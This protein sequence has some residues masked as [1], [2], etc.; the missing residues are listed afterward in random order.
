MSAALAVAPVVILAVGFVAF[1]VVELFRREA[2]VLPRWAWLLVC[3]ASIPL[4]GIVY[5][6]VGRGE[7]RSPANP[8]TAD[9]PSG[10]ATAPPVTVRSVAAPSAGAT[11]PRSADGHAVQIRGLVKRYGT[12]TALD[13]ISL[14][15][16][17]GSV[18]GLVGPNGA[19]K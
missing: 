11:H 5:L 9:G 16:P 3:L 6:L 12:Q 7:R 18:F 15:V 4:G 10:A 13:G 1:C 8:D 17:T 2:L 14:D 19:G